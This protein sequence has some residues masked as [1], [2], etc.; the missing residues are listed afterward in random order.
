M[1][2]RQKFVKEIGQK[3]GGKWVVSDWRE[4]IPK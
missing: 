4:G 1:R 3:N 2:T